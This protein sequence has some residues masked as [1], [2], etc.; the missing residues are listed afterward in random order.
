MVCVGGGGLGSVPPPGTASTGAD[1]PSA[2][3]GDDQNTAAS[4]SFGD[5]RK[6]YSIINQQY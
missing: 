1:D 3:E 6:M 4:E 2:K 5:V